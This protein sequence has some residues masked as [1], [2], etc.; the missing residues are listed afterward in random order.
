[1]TTAQ[2]AGEA[3]D[4]GFRSARKRV[5][6]ASLALGIFA[7]LVVPIHSAFIADPGALTDDRYVWAACRLGNPLPLPEPLCPRTFAG[8]SPFTILYALVLVPLLLIRGRAR[9]MLAIAI[10]SLT[11]ALLQGVFAF[12]TILPSS[13]FPPDL[14]PNLLP[15]PFERDPATCGLVMCGLDHSLF[16]FSQVPFLLALAFFSYRAYRTLRGEHVQSI[17]Q[18]DERKEITDVGKPTPSS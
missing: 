18:S 2:P 3:P 6:F 5:L 9:T 15:S 12:Y 8:E 1:M 10:L 4:T 14:N 11:F 17:S 7:L 16:H 13:L